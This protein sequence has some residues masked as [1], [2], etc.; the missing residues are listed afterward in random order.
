MVEIKVLSKNL[1]KEYEAFLLSREDSLFYHSTKY[2]DFLED[3]LECDSHYLLAYEGGKIVAALPLMIKDG[4][5]GKVINSLPYYGSNGGYIGEFHNQNVITALKKYVDSLHYASLT[6]VSSPLSDSISPFNYSPT[7]H[8][9]SQMTHLTCGQKSPQEYLLSI[10]DSSARRNIKKAE[11]ADVTVSVLNERALDYLEQTHNSNM[12]S[13]GGKAKTS[14]FFEKFP[15]YFKANSD[16]KIYVA[17]YN[18]QPISALLVFFYNNTV[19]YFTPVTQSAFRDVQPMALILKT[20]MIDAIQQGFTHWNWGGT[21]LN[22]DGVYKFKK[23]WGAVE[24]MYNYATLIKDH[25]ILEVT[26][27]ELNI[28]YEGFYV[29]NFNGRMA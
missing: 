27:S 19:E 14:A 8:R 5:Y 18:N 12:Q 16:Y 23:K 10:I 17:S 3:L 7:D 2:K 1:Y 4:P 26:P 11:A 22:Q 15:R 29:Y 13:I 20:A 9:I 21:W 25:K 24:I 6:M 28:C